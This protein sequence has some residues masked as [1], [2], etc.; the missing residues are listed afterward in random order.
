MTTSNKKIINCIIVEKQI[1]KNVYFLYSTI[2][3][4][5]LL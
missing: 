1:N 5:K 3:Y 4:K 2:I